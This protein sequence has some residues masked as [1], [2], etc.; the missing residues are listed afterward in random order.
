MIRKTRAITGAIAAIVLAMTAL[1]ALA[2]VKIGVLRSAEL[3]AKAP[4][5]K[6]AQDQLKAQFD[7][8]NN[9]LQ[10]EGKKL[11]DD[12]GAYQKEADLLAAADRAKK[13]KD[14]TTRRIDIEAKGRQLQEDF[15][16]ARQE[17]L[18]KAMTAIK[19]VIDAV[20]KEKNLDLVVD[21][22][23]FA[24]PDMDITDDVLKRLQT[25]GGK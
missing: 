18:S 4:Q 20:A 8:R 11:Q 21:E 24:K 10:A 5:F 15:N 17:Q 2:D 3:T 14:L 12:I 1:P 13:E 19:G 6:A 23:V 22:P 9:D 25:P 7:R 16:K